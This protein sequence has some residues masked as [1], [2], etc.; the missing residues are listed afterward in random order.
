MLHLIFLTTTS[1]AI[2]LV[3]T[4]L[5]V[6]YGSWAEFGH[7]GH[8]MLK[9]V[10]GIISLYHNRID[11]VVM[12]VVIPEPHCLSPSEEEE[13]AEK[14]RGESPPEPHSLPSNGESEKEEKES[15]ESPPSPEPKK[16]VKRPPPL[17][18]D[19]P[20]T[21]KQKLLEPQKSI[22]TAPPL[23]TR[24][25]ISPKPTIVTDPKE[26]E[27]KKP[28]FWYRRISSKKYDFL[29]FTRKDFPTVEILQEYI[30]T[31][32]VNDSNLGKRLGL[33]KGKKDGGAETAIGSIQ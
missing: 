31:H 26:I 17:R 23:P 2:E 28:L 14:E 21:K 25:V 6:P 10:D 3:E 4:L 1:K 8:Y 22:E 13:L 32:V 30:K 24:I 9:K 11:N 7:S 27:K 20:K 29:E 33:K 15:G 19:N 16:G 5:A 18:K 12:T